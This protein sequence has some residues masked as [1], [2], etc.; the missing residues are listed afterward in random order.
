M[1]ILERFQAQAGSAFQPRVTA[2]EVLD[3]L[4]KTSWRSLM[5]RIRVAYLEIATTPLLL[6]Q[7]TQPYIRLSSSC[8][9]QPASRV[10]SKN[11]T[12]TSLSMFW[13]RVKALQQSSITGRTWPMPGRM[14]QLFQEL[15]G[16]DRGQMTK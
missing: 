4:S 14:F 5:V 2:R 16:F 11:E 8:S 6:S 12:F 1:L 9:S 10:S 7:S 15:E 3:T 13:G